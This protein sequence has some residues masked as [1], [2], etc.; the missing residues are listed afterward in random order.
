MILREMIEFVKQHHSNLGDKEIIM[1]LNEAMSDFSTDT[2]IVDGYVDFDTVID[3]RY[4]DLS[5]DVLE[6]KEVNYDVGGNTIL[7]TMS[8]TDSTG[9][10]GALYTFTLNAG[11]GLTSANIGNSVTLSGFTE[12]TDLNG[13]T[14]QLK[15]LATNAITLE[16]VISTNTQET[17]ATASFKFTTSGTS[18][19]KR[20]PRLIGIP[21]E[22]DI[23]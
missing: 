14:T 20:I 15:S 10:A 18:K 16:G 7:A 21:D 5:D 4:Y 6:I 22:R 2:R 8:T 23:G 17:S 19:G 9:A 3:K 11:H 12:L 13:L 1:L